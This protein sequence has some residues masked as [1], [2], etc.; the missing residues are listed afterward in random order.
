MVTLCWLVAVFS[1]S[2][3]LCG[4][5]LALAGEE[6]L[7]EGLCRSQWFYA[8]AGAVVLLL[9]L[10]AYLLIDTSNLM[11]FHWRLIMQGK[12]TREYYKRGKL[13]Y[14]NGRHPFDQG[15]ACRN[16]CAFFSGN[17]TDNVRI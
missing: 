5:F 10:H 16:I 4:W 14:H 7:Q 17:R 13:A 3:I 2:C 11:F 15:S 8:L 12:T 6:Y 1:Y 9:G